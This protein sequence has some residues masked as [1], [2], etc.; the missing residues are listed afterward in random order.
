MCIYGSHG[1]ASVAIFGQD[2]HMLHAVVTRCSSTG[3][4]TSV[5]VISTLTSS[6]V[7][8]G[9]SVLIVDSLSF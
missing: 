9:T 8:P 7:R 6:G 5:S 2:D 3:T 4:Y 1:G